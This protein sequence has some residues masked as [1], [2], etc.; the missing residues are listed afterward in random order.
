MGHNLTLIRG[1]P[2][3]GKTTLV[4]KLKDNSTIVLETDDILKMLGVNIDIKPSD[5][6]IA[7]GETLF[8]SLVTAA[9]DCDSCNIIVSGVYPT[10]SD[11]IWFRKLASKRNYSFNVIDMYSNWTSEKPI[12]DE[13]IDRMKSV[14]TPTN[15]GIFNEETD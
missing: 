13:I 5:R 14:W 4:N 12:P 3:S 11:V 7:I 6:I 9:M 2:G 1:L 10:L 15:G 8:I